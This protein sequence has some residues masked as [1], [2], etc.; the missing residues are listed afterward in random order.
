MH[1]SARRR[2]RSIPVIQEVQAVAALILFLLLVAVLLGVGTA[3]HALLWIGIIAAALWLA[4]FAFRPSGRR[5]Y[6]W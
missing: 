5:W 4:G 3:V 6:Y 1:P 2:Q